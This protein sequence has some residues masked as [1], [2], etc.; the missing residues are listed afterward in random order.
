LAN[1]SY[2]DPII[3]AKARDDYQQNVTVHVTVYKNVTVHVTVY[4]NVTVHVT[5]YKNV[6]VH[7]TVYKNVTVHVTVY[8]NVTV[9]VTVYKNVLAV[10]TFEQVD[11]PTRNNNASFKMCY[12]PMSVPLNLTVN[13]TL[14][15]GL[16]AKLCSH[17]IFIPTKVDSH[18]RISPSQM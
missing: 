18:N 10:R 13:A 17:I 15:Y 8:T 9:H 1:N 16:D 2:V 14:P 6:T 4:K 11:V 7:V 5:V 12:Y 3:S